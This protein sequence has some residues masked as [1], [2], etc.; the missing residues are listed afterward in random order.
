MHGPVDQGL[1]LIQQGR[2][3]GLVYARRDPAR[4]ECSRCPGRIALAPRKLVP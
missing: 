1:N 2:K 3:G 4:R